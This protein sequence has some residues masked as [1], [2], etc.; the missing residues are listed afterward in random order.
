VKRWSLALVVAACGAPATAPTTIATPT[1]RDAAIDAPAISDDE[2]LAAIQKAMNDLA[3]AVQG[4]WAAVAAAERFDVAGA[5]AAQIDIASPPHVTLV[6]DT[7]NNASLSAC[8]TTILEAYRWPPPLTGQSIQLPFEFHAP[9]GQSVIDRRL[10]PEHVQGKIAVSVLLDET[11]TGNPAASMLGVTIAAGGATG[12]RAAD[13]DQIWY[14]TV[15]DAKVG[16]AIVS[17]GDMIFVPKGSVFDVAA[18]NGEV[19][20]VVVLVPG[21][22]E[23]IARAGALPNRES[24]AKPGGAIVLHAKDAKIWCRDHTTNPDCPSVQIFAEP[25]T[26]H[27]ASLSA[28][29]LHIRDVPEHDHAHETELVY[30]ESGHG[31]LTVGGIDLPI[32]DTSVTQVPAGIRHSFRGEMNGFQVYTPA[33]P[34]QRFKK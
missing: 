32:T 19:H 7:A 24:T 20:A 27:A 1:P 3:P 6:R 5:I 4:C 17:P 33:G 13:R 34:E 29:R 25:S 30:V 12:P 15:N 21:G 22:R 26:I 14:V 28:S 11:T 31:V 8:V 2:K 10:V 18:A 16:T 9:D 23:G